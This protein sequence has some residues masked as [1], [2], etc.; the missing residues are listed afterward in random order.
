MVVRISKNERK[1]T[2]PQSARIK[3]CKNLDRTFGVQL[4]NKLEISQVSLRKNKY[5]K[6]KSPRIHLPMCANV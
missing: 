2:D 5:A 3:E 6:K 1:S 4:L